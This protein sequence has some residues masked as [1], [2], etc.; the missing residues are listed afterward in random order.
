[1]K[2]ENKALLENKLE[3]KY[4][5]NMKKRWFSNS[6]DDFIANKYLMIEDN[7]FKNISKYIQDLQN[8]N[9]IINQIKHKDN[10]HTLIQENDDEKQT[11]YYFSTW[12]TKLHKYYLLDLLEEI[13]KYFYTE[14][15]IKKIKN[16]NDFK[17]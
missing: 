17:I 2:S 7:E 6:S 16:Q 3:T 10:N 14:D 15:V 8:S 12:K 5:D 13:Y 1:M 9:L 4:P 11:T